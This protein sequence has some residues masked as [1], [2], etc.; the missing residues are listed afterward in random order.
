M[1]VSAVARRRR[2]LRPPAAATGAVLSSTRARASTSRSSSASSRTEMRMPV[3]KTRTA[4]PCRS[5][6]SP[7]ARGSSTGTKRKFAVDGKRLEP[8]RAQRAREALAFLHDRA[9]VRR[10]LE[11]GERERRGQR[12]DGTRRLPFVQLARGVR[13]GDRVA[14]PRGRE[15]ERLRERADHDHAVVDQTDRGLAAVLEIRL[16]DD[17][18][19]SLRQRIERAGRVVRPAAER[20]HGIVVADLRAREPRADPEE[21]VRRL[22]GDRDRVTGTCEGARAEQD[23]V[24]RARAEHDVLRA[25]AGVARDRVDEL[26][27]AAVRVRVDARERPRRSRPGA[28]TAGCSGDVRVEADDLDRIDPRELA[29]S[30]VDGAQP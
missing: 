26:R 7:S 8:E 11:R 13:V 25:D 28:T 21:R 20:Q 24:V 9:H 16:V 3:G 6:A 17:E 18:R 14:H 27:I 23:Q 1:R 15:R 4:S 22:V 5:S 29:I 10:R 30:A 12:R 19:P 2:T